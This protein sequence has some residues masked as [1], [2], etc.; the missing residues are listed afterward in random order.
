VLHSRAL[1][2]PQPSI[3]TSSGKRATKLPV[4]SFITPRRLRSSHKGQPG[5]SYRPLSN[6]GRETRLLKLTGRCSVPGHPDPLPHFE[7]HHVSFNNGPPPY[8]SVSYTWGDPNK[9]LPIVVDGALVSVTVNLRHALDSLCSGDATGQLFWVDALCINQADCHE[10]TAQV[11]MM[12]QIF[13][14]ATT[15]F[16]WVGPKGATHSDGGPLAWLQFLATPTGATAVADMKID[17]LSTSPE[18]RTTL[19]FLQRGYWS[20]VWVVQELILSRDVWVV[21]GGTNRRIRLRDLQAALET[22]L[23]I[24]IKGASVSGADPNKYRTWYL[25]LAAVL[26]VRGILITPP[27]LPLAELLRRF[28]AGTVGREASGGWFA[29]DK[30]DHVFSL[31]NLAD[32]AQALGLKPD[33]TKSTEQIFLEVNRALLR[34]GIWFHLGSGELLSQCPPYHR[35][36]RCPE[37]TTL[38]SWASDLAHT[39]TTGSS[40][41]SSLLFSAGGASSS[42]SHQKPKFQSTPHSNDV[43]VIEGVEAGSVRA[44]G[45]SLLDMRSPANGLLQ[46]SKNLNDWLEDFRSFLRENGAP[47]QRIHDQGVMWRVPVLDLE[48]AP[49]QAR[50]DPNA[51][52]HHDKFRRCTRLTLDCYSHLQKART[53]ERGI[54]RLPDS[55]TREQFGCYLNW[56]QLQINTHSPFVTENGFLGMSGHGIRAGDVIIVVP[57]CRVPFLARLVKSGFYK[58]V[59]PCYVHGI[60]DGELLTAERYERRVFNFI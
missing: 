9:T 22:L 47:A 15:T 37:L 10:K 23:A 13:A 31:L 48:T 35:V 41:E 44:V 6:T 12:H 34:S 18:I 46:A 59:G 7:L 58:L 19:E 51:P 16:A 49:F 32:D 45:H 57:H 11:Q 56:A 60:M 52:P 2:R 17:A 4:T 26:R 39:P 30:R 1:S 5:C 24:A 28:R 3:T 54:S 20:R 14:D 42:R 43:L 8:A 27:T 40:R 33:Y 25:L 21:D 36:S 38:P 53:G 29:T 50:S 55:V